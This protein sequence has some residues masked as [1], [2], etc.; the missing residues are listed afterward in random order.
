MTKPF[1]AGL[2]TFVIMITGHML[3][4]V[5]DKIVEHGVGIPSILTFMLLQVPFAML[6]SLPASS[7]LASSLALNRLASEHELTALRA[8]GVGLGRVLRPAIILGL[9]ASLLAVVLAQFVVPWANH[10]S[11]TLLTRIVAQRPALAFR[12]GQ[13]TNT[14]AG[15]DFFAEQVDRDRGTLGHL[16]FFNRI[17]KEPPLLMIAKEAHFGERVLEIG[18]ADFYSLSPGGSLT[19]GTNEGLRIDLGQLQFLPGLTAK[20]LSDMSLSELIA[21]RGRLETEA[22]G[23]GRAASV[24]LHFRLSLA[25]ACLIFCVLALPATL[26][27]A[28]GQSL[29]GVLTTLVVLFVYYVIMLWLRM[30]AEAGHMP[31][32]LAAWL[33]DGILL[34]AALTALWRHR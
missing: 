3:F 32:L 12:P 20:N 19:W 1:L 30:A 15:L 22:P 23:A 10:Q 34:V 18:P 9:G 24:E 11:Q 2:A 14:G 28:R 8:G 4:T 17:G 5:V 33:E 21:E 26:A 31:P 6:L 27:F 29:V 7:L 25:F 13:F 16:Y